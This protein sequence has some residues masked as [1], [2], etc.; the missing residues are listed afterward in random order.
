MK[1]REI[2]GALDKIAPPQ[3]AAD[4][5]N[6]GLL[7]GDSEASARK[8]MLCIDLTEQVLAEAIKAKATMVM[9]YHPVIFKSISRLTAQANPVVHAACAKGI[10]V[11]SMHTALDVAPGGTND[12]LADLLGIKDAR[13]IEPLTQSGGYK[14]IV[15]T[16]PENF[17]HVADAAFDAGAGTIGNYDRCTFFSHGI[18]TYYG[19]PQ[20]KPVLGQ[21]GRQEADEEIRLELVTPASK[22]TSVCDAIRASHMFE[23]PAIDIYRLAEAPAGVGMGR[24]GRL[25]RPV[26]AG[27]LINRI[28]KQTGLS[29]VLLAKPDSPRG[30]GKGQLVSVAACAAGSCGSMYKLAVEAGATFYLTGEM[31]HH[32]A[33]AATAAGLTVLCLG[34]SNSE[35]MT[36]ARLVKQLKVSLPKLAVSVAKSDADPFSIV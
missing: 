10:A 15:F 13:P 7:V 16:P 32:D 5:D 20:S 14:V 28:K 36:L 35:R 26:M 27:T 23:T 1:V 17:P 8:M 25:T 21:S 12:V 6:V 11:Y 18:G 9:A 19:G 29:K 3:Y 34:H 33:L 2:V 30:N 22:L 4:W 24:I 31:R